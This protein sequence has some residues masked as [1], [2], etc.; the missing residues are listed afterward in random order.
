MKPLL[1]QSKKPADKPNRQNTTIRLRFRIKQSPNRRPSQ[2]E[3]EIYRFCI[4]QFSWHVPQTSVE[5]DLTWFFKMNS[6]MNGMRGDPF[7]RF[8]PFP[9]FYQL[10]KLTGS[11]RPPAWRFVWRL[12]N[13]VAF[14]NYVHQKP[15]VMNRK[16]RWKSSA[17]T[18]FFKQVVI[19]S[20]G[21]ANEDRGPQR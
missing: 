17:E 10:N 15:T 3:Q 7:Q 21:P 16:T 2:P 9:R 1:S 13:L 11:E 8:F 14:I 20:S 19:E 5:R 18:R 12:V 4:A 6:F